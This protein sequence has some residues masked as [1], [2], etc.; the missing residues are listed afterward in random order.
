L[1]LE[2]ST[3]AAAEVLTASWPVVVMEQVRGG[4]GQLGAVVMRKALMI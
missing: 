3:A 1:G 4:R 2:Y